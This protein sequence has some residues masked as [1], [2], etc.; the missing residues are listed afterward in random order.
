[1]DGLLAILL[2]QNQIIRG[3]LKWLAEVR[4]SSAIIRNEIGY[5]FY[6]NSQEKLHIAPPAEP[7]SAA[8][9]VPTKF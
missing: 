9:I 1:M 2:R 5:P 7:K 6:L 8:A 3:G 4:L